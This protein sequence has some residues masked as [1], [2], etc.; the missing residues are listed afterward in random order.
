M[1]PQAPLSTDPAPRRPIYPGPR[2]LAMVDAC[3]RLTVGRTGSTYAAT[4]RNS[5]AFSG[6]AWGRTSLGGPGRACSLR[7]CLPG[8]RH[9]GLLCPRIAC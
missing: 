9:A 5:V 4:F 3:P 2:T 7:P 1:G 8:R 6:A